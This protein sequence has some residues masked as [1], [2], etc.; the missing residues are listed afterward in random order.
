MKQSVMFWQLKYSKDERESVLKLKYTFEILEID[1]QQMAV[2]VG[3]G[4]D[5]LHGILKLNKSAA[6]ILELLKEETT[7]EEIVEKLLEKYDEPKEELQKYVHEYMKELE[8][9]EL[10]A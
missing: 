1:E 2:P 6:A 4:A 8:E 3:E 10:L 9:A 5:E 7:E